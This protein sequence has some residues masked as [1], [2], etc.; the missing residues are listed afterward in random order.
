MIRPP[1]NIS[2]KK[3]LA[4]IVVFVGLPVIY[5]ITWLMLS[6]WYFHRINKMLIETA[7]QHRI[8]IPLQLSRSGFPFSISWYTEGLQVATSLLDRELSFQFS[9]VVFG[10]SL[11]DPT[12]LNINAERAAL[13]SVNQQ[14]EI[15]WRFRSNALEITIDKAVVGKPRLVFELKTVELLKQEEITTNP[16]PRYHAVASNMVITL[17]QTLQPESPAQR[18]T[19]DVSLD[20]KGIRLK[21]SP[22]DYFNDIKKAHLGMS[23]IGFLDTS[24]V[25]GVVDWRDDGGTIE[26]NKLKVE[27][28]PI[29]LE[30]R[31][32]LSLDQELKP[33]G[34]GTVLVYRAEEFIEEKIGTGDISR[35]EGLM[36]QL[37][38][39][40]L[41]RKMNSNGKLSIQIPIT[42]QKGKLQRGP[43]MIT[44]LF[45]IVG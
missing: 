45:S 21:P 15:S 8:S 36:I 16:N 1:L 27:T 34:A 22:L 28:A 3:Q 2:K 25:S 7:S 5:C 23:I 19:I 12:T 43:F 40:L 38:L 33:I 24:D 14:K 42:A 39:S 44:E 37:A 10:V 4:I 41:P 9:D 6:Q 30:M 18:P 35:T 13:T 20:L 29:S 17:N 11:L 32:T 31:G 26:I